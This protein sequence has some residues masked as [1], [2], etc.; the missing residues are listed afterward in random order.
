MSEL[1]ERI[2]QYADA[3]L[4]QRI[5]KVRIVMDKDVIDKVAK[6]LLDTEGFEPKEPP[7]IGEDIPWARHK[8]IVVTDHIIKLDNLTTYFEVSWPRSFDEYVVKISEWEKAADEYS[9]EA[10]KI[11]RELENEYIARIRE[12]E[13][14]IIELKSI[15]QK[16]KITG[17][18]LVTLREAVAKIV[19]A[20]I[21]PEFIGTMTEV[22]DEAAKVITKKSEEI[23]REVIL[24]LMKILEEEKRLVWEEGRS[25]IISNYERICKV[26]GTLKTLESALELF[27]KIRVLPH[28]AYL[29][30][31]TPE[32]FVDKVIGVLKRFGD[33]VF[34]VISIAS[35]DV[36]KIPT[37]TKRVD[38][39]LDTMEELTDIYGTPHHK[40]V[41]PA[42]LM[43]FIFPFI[44]AF[45]FPDWGHALVLVLFGWGLLRRKSWA[46]SVFKPF[47][48]K[49]FGS[50]TDLIGRLMLLV[51]GA[52]IITGLLAGEFFGPLIGES[53]ANIAMWFFKPF[54]IVPPLTFEI[55]Y[56]GDTV[57][58]YIMLSLTIGYFHL[59][60]GLLIGFYN[61]YFRFY[62]RER[63]IHVTLPFLFMYLTAG[64]PF[65]AGFIASGFGT[66]IKAMLDTAGYLFNTLM[67][68]LSAGTIGP[69]FIIFLFSL[70]WRG[71]GIYMLEKKHGEASLSVVGMEMFESFVWVL[72]NTVSYLRIMALALAHWGLMFAF[73]IIGG[74]T[75][76]VG[77]I[78]IYIIANILVIMLEGL[79]SFVHDLRLHFY[80]WFTKFYK[81]DGRRFRPVRP[82]VRVQM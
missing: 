30:G 35:G 1:M 9:A 60:L 54:G 3:L 10:E 72:S 40:E 57:I 24:G 8:L 43:L 6:A 55:H 42:P 61:E 70:L 32:D 44:Y 75:G 22:M 48:V 27:S 58:K 7:E 65:A 12:L 31:Y 16:S 25:W 37:Y 41:S 78:I 79:I 15:L 81:D 28:V 62:S 46:L 33:K 23:I 36:E 59:L 49:R 77:L 82:F 69:L 52:S 20:K 80:E 29:E 71:Y 56:L 18:D 11:E 39:Y 45:M 21:P 4:P 66:N 14:K 5:Y 76:I 50:G 19:K 38:E 74:L 2:S 34:S 64:F 68:N 73:Q 47:G 51:G 26:Y 13:N 53:Y 63:A 67:F 17:E